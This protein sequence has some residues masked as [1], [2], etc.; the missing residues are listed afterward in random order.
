MWAPPS[1]IEKLDSTHDATPFECGKPALDDWLKRYALT[2]QKT[3][4]AVT[5]VTH[6]DRVVVGYYALAAGS[7][8]REEAPQRIVKGL[9]KH[10]VP[11]VLLA[12][13]AV[14][15]REAG[16]GLG[17]ALLKDAFLRIEQAADIIGARAAL[18]HAI[19]DDARRFY[20]HFEF[21]SSPIDEHTLMLLM[22]DLRTALRT[23]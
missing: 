15:H 14:D 23:K 9:A 6:R 16:H 11:V 20:A 13:L 19:D 3:G 18:V 4:A 12:R 7:V 21:E 22:K 1:G 17:A 2:N 8:Q 10:P 5:Y